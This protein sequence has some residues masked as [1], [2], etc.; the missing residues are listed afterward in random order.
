MLTVSELYIYP[1]KSMAGIAVTNAAVTSR[2]LQYDRRLMLVDENNRFLT[3]REYPV[4]ALLRPVIKNDGLYIYHKKNTNAPL[5]IPHQTTNA[6]T[7]TVTIWDDTCEGQ[8]YDAQINDWFS[9]ALELP[10]KLVYMP[11]TSN[12][13]V[14]KR[15]ALNKEITSFADG[16][17]TL[18]IGQS[19][20]D[21][22]NTRLAEAIPMNRFRPNIVFTGGDAFL[23]DRMQSFTIN[24]IYFN[25]VKP[26][27]RCIMTTIDQ[28]TISKSKEPLKTLAGYRF[29]DNKILFGQN[30]LHEGDGVISIGD[31]INV[32]SYQPAAIL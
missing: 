30:L 3:Q 7:V 10:C 11:D 19:S 1:V 27:A 9:K 8:L 31:I 23:E 26:C 4:M 22:L 18:I 17:P 16:Y 21:D 2:G 14:D 32:T 20:L 6:E 29:K 12:R 5:F 28:D 25:G 24:G 13:E 15:F